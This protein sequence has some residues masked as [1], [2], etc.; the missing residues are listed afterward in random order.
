MVRCVVKPENKPPCAALVFVRDREEHLEEMHQI[1]ATGEKELGQWFIEL[2]P[3][4]DGRDRKKR[5]RR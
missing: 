2:P 4:D 5:R 3:E 1:F